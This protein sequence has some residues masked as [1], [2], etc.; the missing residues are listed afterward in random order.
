[1]ADCVTG[2]CEGAVIAGQG[3][4]PQFV[5]VGC[6]ECGHLDLLLRLPFR[7]LLQW[8][9]ESRPIN[10]DR[11]LDRIVNEAHRT[12]TVCQSPVSGR[13]GARATLAIREA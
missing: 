2:K 12:D 7:Q 10:L 3:L 4:K 1:V 5:A 6:N 11:L 9:D 13:S 8:E